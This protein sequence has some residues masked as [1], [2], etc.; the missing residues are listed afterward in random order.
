MKTMYFAAAMVAA[1][2][3]NCPTA[4]AGIIGFE[5]GFSDLDPVSAVVLPGENTVTFS[6][7]SKGA[8]PGY[9][10]KVGGPQT[11]FAPNDTPV[12]AR[13][14]QYFLTDEPNG[15][16]VALDYFMEFAVPVSHLSL[17]LYDFRGDG[18]A[19]VGS[20]VKL[21]L[22]SAANVLVGVD[23]FTIPALLP[24]GNV[25]NLAVLPVAAASWASLTFDRGDIGTGIDNVTIRTVP[26]PA[27][28]VLGCLGVLGIFACRNRR[29]ERQS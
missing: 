9:I 11:A 27:T 15:P 29:R 7:G 23:S 19:P 25:V 10:A 2:G 22:Y 24:E 16:K 26:E 20:T 5:S 14:G 21:S 4:S 1:I 12:G 3:F 17:Q 8:G 6:V 18:G 28:I 13:A